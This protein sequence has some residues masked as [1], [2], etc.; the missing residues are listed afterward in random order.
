MSKT[1]HYVF[2]TGG[3]EEREGL[4]L[5]R[6]I[7]RM[8]KGSGIKDVLS[9]FF[10]IMALYA[11][12]APVNAAAMTRIFPELN[13]GEASWGLFLLMVVFPLI[14]AVGLMT[15]IGLSYSEKTHLLQRIPFASNKIRNSLHTLLQ[16]HPSRE[17]DILHA[18]WKHSRETQD[19][20]DNLAWLKALSL[21]L[22]EDELY[23]LELMVP[24]SKHLQAAAEAVQEV[25][26]K[27]RKALLQEEDREDVLRFANAYF[28]ITGEVAPGKNPLSLHG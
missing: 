18:W 7:W 13:S 15:P 24:S 19:I 17:Q 22:Q 21:L 2:T 5:H 16:K 25:G 10:L 11:L 27:R 20:D 12:F 4:S 8:A 26:T 6:R 28:Y 1:S 23:P 9:N 3:V 14:L